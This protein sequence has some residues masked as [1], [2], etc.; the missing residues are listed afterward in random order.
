VREP[1]HDQDEER[2]GTALDGDPDTNDYAEPE[3][4]RA[5]KLPTTGLPGDPATNDF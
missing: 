5:S 1:E 4:K 2:D 3:P